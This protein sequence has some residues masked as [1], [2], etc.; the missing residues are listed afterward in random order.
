MILTVTAD[1]RCFYLIDPPRRRV[2]TS[3]PLSRPDADNAKRAITHND[4]NCELCGRPIST[5]RY[6]NVAFSNDH[7]RYIMAHVDCLNKKDGTGPV[8]AVISP[9]QLQD[10]RKETA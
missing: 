4:G 1:Q 9:E 5:R 10:Y 6:G 2:I 7:S 3:I 8:V